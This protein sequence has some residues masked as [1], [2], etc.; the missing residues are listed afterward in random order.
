M[1]FLVCIDLKCK[2][3]N[4]L[5]YFATEIADV[6]M[7]FKIMYIYAF[8]YWEYCTFFRLFW[9]SKIALIVSPVIPIKLMYLCSWTLYNTKCTMVNVDK[10]THCFL[11]FNTYCYKI[12]NF[13]TIH[14]RTRVSPFVHCHETITS[15]GY[16]W[17]KHSNMWDMIMYFCSLFVPFFF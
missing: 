5:K 17:C 10:S 4:S 13:L 15:L 12:L 8:I 6:A 11:I 7:I 16:S 3:G 1:R 14:N 9:V 2:W